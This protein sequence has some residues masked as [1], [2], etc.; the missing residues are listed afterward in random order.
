MND[1]KIASTAKA[2]SAIFMGKVLVISRQGSGKLWRAVRT[3][4]L[5][6][7]DDVGKLTR[8]LRKADA[9]TFKS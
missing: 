4:P 9:L 7:L 8:Q 1:T 2:Q 6:P 5:H 3:S